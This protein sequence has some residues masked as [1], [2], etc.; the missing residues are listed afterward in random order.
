MRK[1]FKESDYVGQLPLRFSSVEQ[2]LEWI[3]TGKIPV[4]APP[5]Y[6]VEGN[7]AKSN[8]AYVDAPFE[9][10]VWT[11]QTGFRRLKGETGYKEFHQEFLAKPA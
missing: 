7:E 1:P 4:G 10:A 9:V 3:R 5:P 8:P 2:G 11:P 6:V